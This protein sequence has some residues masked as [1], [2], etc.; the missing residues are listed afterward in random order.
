VKGT[1]PRT[2]LEA[3]LARGIVEVVHF[4]TNLG[5][6][7][8]LAMGEILPRS[9]LRQEQLL[10]HIVFNNSAMRM[11]ESASF[12]KTEKWIDYVNLSI[13][14]ITMSLFRPSQRWHATKDISWFIL[15][16][17]IALLGNSGVYF[18]AT[19]NIYPSTSRGTGVAGFERLF[20]PTV[21]RKPGW[22]AH[23]SDRARHQTTCEQA[24]VLYPHGVPMTYLRK[25]YAR[26]GE[27]ADWVHSTLAIYGRS[28]VEVLLEPKKFNGQP[29]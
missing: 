1:N 12:D 29:N 28:D 18:S 27:D 8:C 2:L 17:D 20:G 26:E 22:R 15:S 24:E 19:N 13:S 23:R 4:T 10:K 3:V 7:G 6:L 9:R 11:E 14:D 5:L 16:L 25:V 21:P